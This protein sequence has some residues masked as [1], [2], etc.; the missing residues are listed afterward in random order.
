[1]EE[2]YEKT[3]IIERE[4]KEKRRRERERVNMVILITNHPV[5]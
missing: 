2:N 3:N 1:M 4:K 5:C